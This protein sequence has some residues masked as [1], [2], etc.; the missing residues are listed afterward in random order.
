MKTNEVLAHNIDELKK[1][2]EILI[3]HHAHLEFISLDKSTGKNRSRD[4]FNDKQKMREIQSKVAEIL[5]MERGA[6]KRI[7]GAE[8][9]KPRAYGAMKEREKAERKALNDELQSKNAKNSDFNEAFNEIDK[10]LGLPYQD[11]IVNSAKSY[12][13]EIKKNQN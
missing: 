7:S 9:I 11:N 3:N 8:R 12:I 4:L 6:D 5:E 13:A 1:E 2:Y 10:E